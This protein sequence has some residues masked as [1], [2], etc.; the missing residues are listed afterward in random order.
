MPKQNEAILTF[1]RGIIDDRALSR[2]DIDRVRASSAQQTN[3]LPSVMGSMIIRPGTEYKSSTFNNTF[4]RCVPFSFSNPDLNDVAIEFTQ[5]FIRILIDGVPLTRP[6]VATAVVNGGF[7]TDISGWTDGSDALASIEYSAN[8]N[9]SLKLNGLSVSNKAIAYQ[10]VTVASG[11][12]NVE[13]GIDIT[14]SA[15]PVSIKI[16]SSLGG[17][18]YFSSSNILS[19]ETS[20]SFTP[21]G[22]FFIQIESDTS[23]PNYVNDVRITTGDL[24]ISTAFI[25]DSEINNIRT[26]Q[27][28]DVLYLCNGNRKPRK[29]I[30]R[31]VGS[32]RTWSFEVYD[33]IDGPFLIEN[34]TAI[35]MQVSA[36]TGEAILTASAPYFDPLH[37]GSLFKIEPT[38]QNVEETSDQDN[39]S[40]DRVDVTGVGASRTLSIVRSGT[41]VATINLQRSYDEG[42]T[43]EDVATYTTAGTSTYTDGLNNVDLSYRL[44]V[45]TG[46]YTSGTYTMGINY[47]RGSR[48]GYVKIQSV[49]N[50]M[51]ASVRIVRDLLSTLATENWAEG[52]FSNFQGWP[53][54]LQL[55]E[56]RLYFTKGIEYYA[57]VS[58]AFE[59]FDDTV[60]GDSAPISKTLGSGGS[61]VN[62]MLSLNRLIFG[63][64]GGQK[65][66]RSSSFDEPITPENSTV[67]Q[68]STVPASNIDAIKVDSGGMFISG[69]RIYELVYNSDIFG[70]VPQDLTLLTPEIG[71]NSFTRIAVSRKPETKIHC[72]R[73]DGKVAILSYDPTENLRGWSLWS[74]DGDVEDVYVL[75]TADNG[76]DDIYYIVKRTINGSTVRYHEKWADEREVI[77]G[78]INK[79]LDSHIIVNNVSPSDTIGNLSHLE[80]ETVYVWGDGVDLGSY[81]VSS[82]QV[83]V[84]T[85]VTNAIV[86]LGYTAQYKSVKLP[87][88]SGLG[89]AL[90]QRKIVTMIGFNLVDTH[91]GGFQYGSSFDELYDLPEMIEYAPQDENTI[92]SNYDADMTSFAGLYLTDTRICI[93]SVPNRPA[94]ITAITMGIQTNDK[95]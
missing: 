30:A 39:I 88:A 61:D 41:F 55:H 33:P 47:P 24:R 92:L 25:T 31:G 15:G 20:I 10:E 11:D 52:A 35:T 89:T 9:N 48:V 91:I 69:K 75:P 28:G 70:Y 44:T 65:E 7:D 84:I 56:G 18:D 5:G 67:K 49:T 81:T 77:G 95:G 94:T 63:S 78:N 42:A 29:L 72:V 57:S 1:N 36:R 80:G 86:G 12:L 87:Y 21:T 13:H 85:T 34:L 74:T 23:Y 37:V 60:E 27:S 50:S 59:S 17:D 43:W 46:N 66:L 4:A 68:P 71:N 64:G 40:T 6:S 3:W 83:T 82:G 19:G 22:N 14:V 2:I 53:T 58:D 8:F 73:D 32:D 93:Q 51:T 90:N 45:K 38:G 16:G 26:T 54:A 76:Q 62:W 79:N